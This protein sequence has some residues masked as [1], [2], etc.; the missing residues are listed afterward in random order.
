LRPGRYWT[1]VGQGHAGS[2]TT[3]RGIERLV[4]YFAKNK[5]LDEITDADLAG[6]VAWRRRQRAWG[7][8][9]AAEISPATVNRSTVEPLAKIFTRA[10][11][12]WRQAFPME[13]LVRTVRGCDRLVERRNCGLPLK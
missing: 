2:A 4:A 9:G 12:T 6:L 8:K 5:R 13:P 10:K 11:R 1:E 3:F 7:R